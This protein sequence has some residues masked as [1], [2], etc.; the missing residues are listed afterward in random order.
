MLDLFRRLE[1]EPDT[2]RGSCQ[3][4]HE[5]QIHRIL[6]NQNTFL[7]ENR[8]EDDY[9]EEE[10]DGSEGEYSDDGHGSDDN[11]EEEN[12]PVGLTP[13]QQELLQIVS[14]RLLNKFQTRMSQ[15]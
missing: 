9:E 1:K 4:F 13:Q 14:E 11:E 10:E 12:L 5:W 6:S 8:D 7:A 3:A 2:Y 15:S